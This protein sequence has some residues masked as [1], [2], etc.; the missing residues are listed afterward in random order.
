ML[1]ESVNPNLSLVTSL[2]AVVGLED[3]NGVMVSSVGGLAVNSSGP[4]EIGQAE[5]ENI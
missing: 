1:T 3:I 4:R 5:T 2:E